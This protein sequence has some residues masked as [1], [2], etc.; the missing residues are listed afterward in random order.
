MMKIKGGTDMDKKALY[1]LS[2]G[3]FMLGVKSGDKT[4]GCI[5]NTCMQVASSPDRVAFSVLNSN[6]TCDLLKEGGVCTISILDKSVSFDTIKYF[7]MQSGRDVDKMSPVPFPTDERGV[8]YMGWGACAMLSLRVVE[9]KDLGSHTLFIAETEDARVLS[10]EEPITYAYY[11]NVLK[12]KPA[13]VKSEKRIVG[14]RCR[15]CG[16]VYEGS[17]LPADFACPLCS[18]G[19]DDFEPIYEN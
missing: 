7:G 13:A 2:Y 11:Q 9:S 19:A 15:I 8:P 17:E 3:V 10:N 5:T 1:A 18:H 12:P 14:W 6:Y 4:N 16:Y